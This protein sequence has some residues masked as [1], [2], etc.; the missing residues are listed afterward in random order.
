MV[1]RLREEKEQELQQ[2]NQDW[3]GK[4]DAREEEV[5]LTHLMLE[6]YKDICIIS[7]NFT[8]LME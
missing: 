6:L 7:L 2:L 3:R 5:S 4:M 8:N 1:M